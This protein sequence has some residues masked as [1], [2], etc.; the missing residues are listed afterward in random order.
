MSRL[1]RSILGLNIKESQEPISELGLDSTLEEKTQ[2]S[3]NKIRIKIE[4]I[5]KDRFKFRLSG[6]LSDRKRLE[7]LLE[8]IEEIGQ[9]ANFERTFPIGILEETYNISFDLDTNKYG[10]ELIEAFKR[11]MRDIIFLREQKII[12]SNLTRLDKYLG[13]WKNGNI[14]LRLSVGE[15]MKKLYEVLEDYGVSIEDVQSKNKKYGNIPA[16]RAAISYVLYKK[17][18]GKDNL[19]LSSTIIGKI[20]GEKNHATV[21]VGI[22]KFT[23][24]NS[25]KWDYSNIQKVFEKVFKEY[26]KRRI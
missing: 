13:T 22:K 1:G 15:D 3:N 4:K 19:K 14:I 11:I 21:L 12:M 10:T 18:N 17:Y 20:L 8:N 23:E 25:E 24:I 5:K 7:D 9:T 16:A 2:I 6:K 26:H